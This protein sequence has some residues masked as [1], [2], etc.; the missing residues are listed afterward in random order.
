MRR[1]DDHVEVVDLLELLA[2]GP[3]RTGHARQLFVH[4]EVVLEGDARQRHVLALDVHAFFGLDRLVQA[5]RVATT[6]HQ[7]AGELVDDDDLTFR[8]D[9]VLVVAMEQ[10]LGFERVVQEVR[11]LRC[12]RDRRC[13]P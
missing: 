7:P 11:E 13:C 6:G 8:I 5:L 2:L 3:R 1:H 4:A 10:E 12:S 9:D